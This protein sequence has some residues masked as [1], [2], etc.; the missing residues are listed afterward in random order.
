MHLTQELFLRLAKIY[1][2]TKLKNTLAFDLANKWEEID[3][4]QIIQESWAL[5]WLKTAKKNG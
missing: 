2:K 1:G 4:H 3:Y 5:M